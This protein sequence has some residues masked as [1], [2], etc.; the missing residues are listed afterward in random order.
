MTVAEQTPVPAV[1]APA[2]PPREVVYRHGVVVRA[3]HWINALCLVLL[4]MS[5]LRIFNYHPS[6]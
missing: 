5:G 4:L 2:A 3:T 6:L 1:A